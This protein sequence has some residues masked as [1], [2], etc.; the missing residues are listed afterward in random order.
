MTEDRKKKRPADMNRRA[1]EVVQEAVGEAEGDE[2]EP[3]RGRAGGLKGARHGQR[4]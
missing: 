1:F 4:S 2:D 3:K